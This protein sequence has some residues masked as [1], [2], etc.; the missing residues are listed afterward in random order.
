MKHVS[1]SFG[2]L[3]ALALILTLAP[4]IGSAQGVEL[5]ITWNGEGHALLFMDQG[6]EEMS[7]QC[8]L[9]VDTDGWATGK[10]TAEQGEATLKRFYYEEEVEGARALVMIYVDNN[11]TNPGLYIL[12]ARIL[13]SKLLYGEIFR[14]PFDK[15]GE[16]EKSLTLG[17]NT[18][19]QIFPD[20]FP[21]SLKKAM[22]KCK[23]VGA[24]AVQG[25]IVK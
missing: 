21:T 19:Q 25:S 5:P 7:I 18:A 6:L 4:A 10:I 22:D 14:K 13:E 15:E 2:W 12:K 11:D 1:F 16:I 8:T 17:D 20:Y 9:K 24:L 23:P 3:S